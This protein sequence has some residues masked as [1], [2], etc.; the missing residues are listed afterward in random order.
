MTKKVNA[1]RCSEEINQKLEEESNKAGVSVAKLCEKIIT[2]HYFPKGSKNPKQKPL[3]AGE[4]IDC[5]IF[6]LPVNPK[7]AWVDISVCDSCNKQED[8]GRACR[9]WELYQSDL[10]LEKAGILSPKTKGKKQNG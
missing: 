1:F 7:G 8:H 2:D 5:P 9:S 10:R 3:R 4:A 6:I